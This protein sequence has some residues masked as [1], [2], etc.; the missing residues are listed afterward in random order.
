V[1]L[2]RFALTP[3]HPMNHTRLSDTCVVNKICQKNR[4]LAIAMDVEKGLLF[5][6]QEA[7]VEKPSSK[8]G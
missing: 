4:S 5:F 8:G 7:L 2:L 1:E 6:S 3:H